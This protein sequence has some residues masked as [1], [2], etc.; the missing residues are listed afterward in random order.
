[1]KTVG[2]DDKGLLRTASAQHDLQSSAA[3]TGDDGIAD[4]RSLRIAARLFEA[5]GMDKSAPVPQAKSATLSMS[6]TIQ[7]MQRAFAVPIAETGAAPQR[8]SRNVLA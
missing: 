7:T 3:T 8:P 4:E 6:N 1:M 5:I 2:Q